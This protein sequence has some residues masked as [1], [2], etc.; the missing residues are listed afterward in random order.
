MPACGISVIPPA[1]WEIVC[2]G[3][4]VAQEQVICLCSGAPLPPSCGRWHADRMDLTEKLQIKPGQSLAIL[5]PPAGVS[6]PAST[7]GA[8]PSTASAVIGFAVHRDD[9]DQLGAVIGAARADRVAWI[10]YPKGGKLG[11]D[12]NR[13]RLAQAL[14]SHGIQPVRQVSIDDTWSALRFRPTAT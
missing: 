6:L 8:Q 9:L 13:D 5:N 3:G 11:T 7:P 1:S 2:G 12:L 4:E 10:G 14:A